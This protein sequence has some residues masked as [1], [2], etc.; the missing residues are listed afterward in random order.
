MLAELSTKEIS[1]TNNPESFNEHVDVARRGGS[2]ARDARIRLEEETGQAVIF[3]SECKR[4]L[5]LEQNKD[6]S[7]KE[8]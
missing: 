3:P 1:E 7:S 5:R 4:G 6:K 2:I 8:Q